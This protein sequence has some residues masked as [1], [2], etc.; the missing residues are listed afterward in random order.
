MNTFF[1]GR[2]GGI[3]TVWRWDLTG[4]A[5]T[6]EVMDAAP[7]QN[8]FPDLTPVAR[9]DGGLGVFRRRTRHARPAGGVAEPAVWAAAHPGAHG[10]APSGTVHETND[11]WLPACGAAISGWDFRDQLQVTDE[12]ITCGRCLDGA[13]RRVPPPGQLELIDLAGLA[14][15]HRGTDH[16]R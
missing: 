8:L 12:E 4:R 5:V 16:R 11:R 10:R 6:V 14:R 9:P 13:A 1:F 2:C 15:L 7:E 3:V